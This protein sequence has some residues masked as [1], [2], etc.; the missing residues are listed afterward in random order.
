[1]VNAQAQYQKV[2]ELTRQPYNPPGAGHQ[3]REYLQACQGRFRLLPELFRQL[4]V[5]G[6]REPAPRIVLATA[7]V[8][9]DFRL[10]EAF[11]RSF[12]HLLRDE[13]GC[14]ERAVFSASGS[15]WPQKPVSW[16]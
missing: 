5:R 2:S 12:T 4:E 7:G 3:K 1:M 11:G 8:A 14:L 15:F 10:G 13:A 16:P 9:A 6:L